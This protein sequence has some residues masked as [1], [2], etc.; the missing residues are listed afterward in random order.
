MNLS[1]YILDFLVKKKVK[2]VFLITGGGFV[3][4]W[5][6]EILKAFFFSSELLQRDFFKKRGIY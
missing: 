4:G 6:A 3:I 1:D 5:V 2:K